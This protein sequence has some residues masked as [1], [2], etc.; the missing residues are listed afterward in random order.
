GYLNAASATLNATPYLSWRYPVLYIQED[1]QV[2]SRVTLNLGARWDY[3]SPPVERYDRQNRGF[4]FASPSSVHA[5]GLDLH[6]GLLFAGVGDLPRGAFR[7]D[8][9]NFQPR[10]GMAYRV[11][12]SKPLVFRAGIG[13]SYL[14]TVDFGG[15]VGFA[16][17]TNAETSSVEGR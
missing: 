11:V 6:G 2:T 9:D 12:R 14:P 5:P 10:F 17:T 1:W 13:R 4:D 3:E 8:W 16:Q 7:R 15:G